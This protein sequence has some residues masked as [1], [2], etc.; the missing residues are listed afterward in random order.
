MAG[1]DDGP[2][3]LLLSG[4]EVRKIPAANQG[5]SPTGTVGAPHFRWEGRAGPEVHPGV[6]CSLAPQR[7][8]RTGPA[9]TPP[10]TR[11]RPRPARE[12]VDAFEA[13]SRRRLVHSPATAPHGS[14][15]G[16][17]D[18][19]TPGPHPDAGLPGRDGRR[20]ETGAR[21]GADTQTPG[22][23][24]SRGPETPVAPPPLS[25]HGPSAADPAGP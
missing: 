22:T 7:V 4:P 6:T 14:G 5:C 20:A 25:S 23:H 10:R 17:A 9:R 3:V 1:C 15:P 8:A 13:T 11:P 12:S 16:T 21:E 18:A 2:G 24:A 19:A